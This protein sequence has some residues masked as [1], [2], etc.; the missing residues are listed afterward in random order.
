[1]PVR[2]ADRLE[3]TLTIWAVRRGLERRLASREVP[4]RLDRLAVNAVDDSSPEQALL[5]L[6]GCRWCKV[7][8]SP[9]RNGWL[10]RLE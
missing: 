6:R 7:V 1:V 8:E 10:V 5:L 3:Q 2:I 9:R 4:R